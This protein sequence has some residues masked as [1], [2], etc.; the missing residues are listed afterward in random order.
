[1]LKIPKDKQERYDAIVRLAIE[2]RHNC[3]TTPYNGKYLMAYHSYC[4]DLG[5]LIIEHIIDSEY[6]KE[7]QQRIDNRWKEYKE[8]QRGNTLS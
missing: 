6:T 1:M 7:K 4:K 2:A 3:D 8:K 5:I